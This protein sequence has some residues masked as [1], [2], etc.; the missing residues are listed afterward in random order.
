MFCLVI[1]W[2]LLSIQKSTALR[3]LIFCTF[4]AL[5]RIKFNLKMV[6][7]SFFHILPHAWNIKITSWKVRAYGIYAGVVG[8]SENSLVR[9]A[10]LFVF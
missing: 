5:S 10:Y 3:C 4:S 1:N 9:Y 7:T 2:Q 6:I 8:V